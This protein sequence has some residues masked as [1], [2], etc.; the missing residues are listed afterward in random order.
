[1]AMVSYIHL[2]QVLILLNAVEDIIPQKSDE[3]KFFDYLKMAAFFAPIVLFFSIVIKKKDLQQMNFDKPVIKRGYFFLITYLV[4]SFLI[5][6]L[7][8]L[9]KKG[10][11]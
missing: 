10:K 1:M 4:L 8:I 11:L 9:Y 2:F 5:L 6:I 7:L 3:G